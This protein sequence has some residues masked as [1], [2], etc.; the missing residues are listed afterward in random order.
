[1]H[2][3]DTKIDVVRDETDLSPQVNMALRQQIVMYV[4]MGV[5]T[6]VQQTDMDVSRSFSTF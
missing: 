3:F 6:S 2:S 4:T 1:L 5:R